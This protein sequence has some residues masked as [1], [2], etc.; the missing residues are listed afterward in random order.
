MVFPKIPRPPD[1]PWFGRDVRR[2]PAVQ[3][4]D[5][6]PRGV[7]AYLLDPPVTRSGEQ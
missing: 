3:G 7:L 4:E 2:R 5:A 1:A 6:E